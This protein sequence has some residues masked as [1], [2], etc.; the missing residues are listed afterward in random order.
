MV[1]QRK[2]QLQLKLEN[3]K[4]I[5]KKTQTC[6]HNLLPRTGRMVDNQSKYFF[7]DRHHLGLNLRVFLWE[8]RQAQVSFAFNQDQRRWVRHGGGIKHY[9]RVRDALSAHLNCLPMHSA[10]SLHGSCMSISERVHI[11]I[12]I[13]QYQEC[14]P[15][16]KWN[17][18][19]FKFFLLP[20]QNLYTNLI[21]TANIQLTARQTSMQIQ[22][23][24][25]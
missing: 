10:R 1:Q 11:H 18:T 14:H 13:W 23:R 15:H 2:W 8:R 9:R 22:V 17:W 6:Q 4:F 5:L 21:F 12:Y 7:Q 3:E 24:V 19:A 25:D 16:S 20:L